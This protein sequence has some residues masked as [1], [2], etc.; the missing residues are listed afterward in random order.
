MI[1]WVNNT[2]QMN[3]ALLFPGLLAA[4]ENQAQEYSDAIEQDVWALCERWVIER[5][6]EVLIPDLQQVAITRVKTSIDE[7][8]NKTP[9]ESIDKVSFIN[10]SARCET[11]TG[12]QVGENVDRI[13]SGISQW[14]RFDKL[15]CN[16]RIKV[17][18]Y[19]SAMEI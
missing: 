10:L 5:C 2:F 8:M 19:V 14:S 13:H 15:I 4:S 6:V 9:V 18:D 3:V 16:L 11:A 1:S 7:G 12:T 17:R